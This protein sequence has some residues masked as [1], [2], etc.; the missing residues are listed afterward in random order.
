MVFKRRDE[1]IHS[2]ICAVCASLLAATAAGGCVSRS[3]AKLQAREAFLAG[4][5]EA[6]ARMQQNQGPTVTIVGEVRNRVVP[7]TEGLTLTQALLAADYYGASDPAQVII[8]RNGIG[9]RYDPRQVLEGLEIGLQPG[10]IV[11]LL[12]QS[13]TPGP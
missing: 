11:Q 3:K 13:S 7:W 10:D 8:V 5:Q 6:I 4:Q 2:V 1:L 9:K 12:S